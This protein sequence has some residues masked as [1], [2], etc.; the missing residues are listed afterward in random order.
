M[1]LKLENIIDKILKATE[2]KKQK[3]R[4]R[5]IDYP[6]ATRI[7][8]T[9]HVSWTTDKKPVNKWG[10]IRAISEKKKDWKNLPTKT[11][12]EWTTKECTLAKIKWALK[13]KEIY[14]IYW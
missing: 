7:R 11:L 4:E 2:K 3:N 8:T 12:T 6:K 13:K 1:A 9:A 5:K 10:K 14:K